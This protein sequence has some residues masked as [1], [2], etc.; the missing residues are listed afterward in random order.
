MIKVTQRCFV[1]YLL[2]L[3]LIRQCK[4]VFSFS[5]L[6]AFKCEKILMYRD[7]TNKLPD[8]YVSLRENLKNK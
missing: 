1:R 7:V 8:G 6:F 3:L 2:P 4:L 5:L